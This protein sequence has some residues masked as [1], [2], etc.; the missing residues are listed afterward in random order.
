MGGRPAS[1]FRQAIAFM[2]LFLR[3]A[4]I[5]QAA[6]LFVAERRGGIIFYPVPM[7]GQTRVQITLPVVSVL[8]YR[9]DPKVEATWNAFQ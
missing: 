8:G 7:P 9:G 4:Y 3:K 2:I 1:R 6:R 5:A